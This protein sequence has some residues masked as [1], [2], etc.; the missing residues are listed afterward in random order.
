MV[1]YEPRREYA[2]VTEAII[3]G[4]SYRLYSVRS[5]REV[6]QIQKHS[7]IDLVI[8]D[9][10][11]QVGEVGLFDV[12]YE[13]HNIGLKG[14]VGLLIPSVLQRSRLMSLLASE[15][16]CL[17]SRASLPSKARKSVEKAISRQRVIKPRYLSGIEKYSGKFVNGDLETDEMYITAGGGNIE[18]YLLA[19]REAKQQGDSR[20]AMSHLV[21][22]FKLMPYSF[23]LYKQILENCHNPQSVYKLA[24][25]YLKNHPVSSPYFNGGAILAFVRLA[26]EFGYS[27]DLQKL[28]DRRLRSLAQLK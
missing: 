3:K 25:R 21:S 1:V 6:K 14:K 23:T 5:L 9:A 28:M 24:S 2:S 10:D 4:G 17:I 18:L 20:R 7:N 15:P 12:M 16:I 11:L 13:L 27:E 22:A 8:M 26:N 19:S